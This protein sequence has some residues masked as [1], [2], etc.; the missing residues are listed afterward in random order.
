[1]PYIAV[2][3]GSS[4]AIIWE[5]NGQIMTSKMPETRGDCIYLLKRIIGSDPSKWIAYQEKISGFIPDGGASM[6]FQFG[7]N[8]ERIGC[9][10]ETL[11]VKI[12]EVNPQEWQRSLG[13]GK[14]ERLRVTKD[15][16]A[17]QK[18][19]VKAYNALKKR[20]WKNKLKSEA[21]RRFP[22]IDVT[23]KNADALLIFEH[24][25]MRGVINESL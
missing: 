23:L 6:M 16:N 25:K 21:Q 15:M 22:G 18:K 5:G 9:I 24:A 14:S 2:D 13:L 1:M 19:N 3:P 4:G 12:I 20:E 17:D 7:R 11:G 8:V 10:L